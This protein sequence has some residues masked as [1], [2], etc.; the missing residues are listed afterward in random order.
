M[1]QHISRKIS[2]RKYSFKKKSQSFSIEFILAFLLFSSAIVVSIKMIS[3]IYKPT[4]FNDLV[5]E[6]ELL[7]DNLLSEGYP[8]NW[9]T[10][11]VI[12]IG[13]LDNNRLSVNKL[14]SLYNMT[15]YEAKTASG[16]RKD[17]FIYF[18]RN[19]SVLNMFYTIDAYNSTIDSCGYGSPQVIQ[20]YDGSKCIISFENATHNN[21]VKISRLAVYNGTI[22]TMNINMWDK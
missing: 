4:D 6:S 5:K 12:K 19:K 18:T 17:F 20:Q 7:S 1:K 11:D 14:L 16:V 2:S 8:I 22:L 9:T 15:Y 3:N 10:D 13:L 21:F